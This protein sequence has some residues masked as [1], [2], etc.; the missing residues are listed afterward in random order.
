MGGKRGWGV[1]VRLSLSKG[2]WLGRIMQ[3]E[4]EDAVVFAK[5]RPKKWV[6]D[7]EAT[8]LRFCSM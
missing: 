4:A 7:G 6:T 3:Q 2:W 8:P 1:R 5:R